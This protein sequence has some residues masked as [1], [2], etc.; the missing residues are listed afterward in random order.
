MSNQ[1]TINFTSREVATLISALS[2]AEFRYSKEIDS[3]Q[4]Q[5]ELN[6]FHDPALDLALKHAKQNL[7]ICESLIHKFINTNQFTDGQQ[8][9]INTQR[10]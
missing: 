6:P 10:G 5:I 1:K 4:D 3:F 9:A 8:A 7:S 2:M